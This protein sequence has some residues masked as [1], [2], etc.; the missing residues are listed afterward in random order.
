MEKDDFQKEE[1]NLKQIIKK[2]NEIMEY[3]DL[4]IEAIP[5]IYKNNPIMIENFIEMYSQKLRLMEKSI[6]KPYFA[7]LDFA[8][9]GEEKVEQL[10]IG[11]VGVMDEENNSITVDWRASHFFNVL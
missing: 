6:K 1:E 2:Y 5:K 10:Y 4:R 9:D 11:K 3:Y 7:R 8:R